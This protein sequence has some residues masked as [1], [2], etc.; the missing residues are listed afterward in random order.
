MELGPGR[1][2]LSALLDVVDNNMQHM[3]DSHSSVD[4]VY[5]DFSKTFDKV[6]MASFLDKIAVG[7]TGNI[8][9][10]LFHFITDRSHFVRL[11]WGIGE[12]HPVSSGIPWGTVLGHLMFLIMISD[13]NKDVSTY[14]LVS[15]AYDTRL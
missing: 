4:M 15:F 11:P 2:C 12:D 8:S 14:K 3:L 9:I 6:P 1:S 5:L 10:W 7:I 13:I